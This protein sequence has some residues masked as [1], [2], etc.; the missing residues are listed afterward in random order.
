[1]AVSDQQILDA[2]NEAILAI[3]TGQAQSVG[4]AGRNFVALGIDKLQDMKR[5]YEDRVTRAT[6]GMFSAS[7]FQPAD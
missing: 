1:M 2:V 3:L 7:R 6:S 4:A 5:E